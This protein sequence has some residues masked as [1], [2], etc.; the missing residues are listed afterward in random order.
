MVRALRWWALAGLLVPVA[1]YIIGFI[2]VFTGRLIMSDYVMLILWPS[3]FPLMAIREQFTV[4]GFLAV[5]I[6]LLINV[7]LYSAVGAIAWLF[8]LL[9][10]R[11]FR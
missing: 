4:F 2:E 1:I 8:W 3:S 9:L 5:A 6:S 11:L 10:S 7:A